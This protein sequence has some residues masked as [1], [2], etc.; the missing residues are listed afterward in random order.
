MVER[1]MTPDAMAATSAVAWVRRVLPDLAPAQQPRRCVAEEG[2]V[3]FIP[4]EHPH[5]PL[6]LGETMFAVCGG[7]GRDLVAVRLIEKRE[8]C[9][10]E[11]PG[12]LASGVWAT[13]KEG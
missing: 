8:E 7:E 6:N 12:R 4:S 1:V 9:V 2:D 10:G 5:L 11:R 13:T 3:V